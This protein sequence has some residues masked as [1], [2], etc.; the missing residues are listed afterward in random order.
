[1]SNGPKILVIDDDV[2]LVETI[3]L[4]LESKGYAVVAANDAQQGLQKV[5]S[6]RPDLILLDIMMPH[7]TEGFHFVWKLRQQSDQYFRTVPIVVLSAIHEKTDLRFYPDTGDETYKAGEYLPVQDF[8]DK[9]VDPAQLLERVQK[10]LA[11]WQ[12]K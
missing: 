3:R 8:V 4:V 12:K 5:E 9:P 1:M 2:D 6:E 10:V 7:G 11:A